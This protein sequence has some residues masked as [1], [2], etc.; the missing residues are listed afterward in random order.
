[1][2]HNQDFLIA[3]GVLRH[4]Y[5]PGGDVMIPEGVTEIGRGAFAHCHSLTGV[6]IPEGVTE[7]G[8]DAFMGCHNL[9]SVT[10]PESVVR[11]GTWAF[12]NCE[13]LTNITIPE[14]V[15]MIGERAFQGCSGLKTVTVSQGTEI[16]PLAFVACPQL[17]D[18][19]GLVIVNGILLVYIGS[20]EEVIIPEN[21]TRIEEDAFAM[22]DSLTSVVIPESV[23]EIG[24]HAFDGCT[25]LIRVTIP[26]SVIVIGE[27][28][29]G[30]C[31][32]LTSVTIPEGVTEIGNSAFYGCTSLTSLSLP[33][34]ITDIGAGA[35][36]G[37][38]G[39]ADEQGM[40]IVNSILFDYK[41]S[42]VDVTI[43]AGVTAISGWDFSC[44]ASVTIPESVV[45]IDM[46]Y[47]DDL[48]VHTPARS[49]A[50]WYFTEC[51]LHP[52][53]PIPD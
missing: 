33:A 5:G 48:I 41:G 39:L 15:A 23:T 31:T 26:E 52:A 13:S 20:G 25:S 24:N 30:D 45:A 19:Q 32:S 53:E 12:E 18:K 21:V 44:G 3:R 1:M 4:Y 22:Q 50:E 35:F 9:A 28:A 43:P 46:E 42:S 7:I 16:G 2:E 11:I 40:V 34:S 14:G 51:G 27:V 47:N 38:D 36:T 10:I 49:Y 37:C 6:V 29:F 8:D 17:A